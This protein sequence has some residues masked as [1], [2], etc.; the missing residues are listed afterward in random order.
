MRT[1]IQSM[2]NGDTR[3]MDDVIDIYYPQIYQFVYRTMCGNDSAKD[4]TQEVFI[5]FLGHLDRYPDDLELRPYLFQIAMNCCRDQFRKQKRMAVEGELLDTFRDEAPSPH[6]IS[7]KKQRAECIKQ[8]LDSLPFEQKTALILRYYH[9]LKF[10]EI[11][12]ILKVS[13]STIKSRITLGMDKL[14]KLLKEDA[15]WMIG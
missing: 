7:M 12:K 14:Q 11:A 3:V 4:I 9:Q 15:S 1:Y 13:E 2:K 8:A 5:R 10:K 6:E